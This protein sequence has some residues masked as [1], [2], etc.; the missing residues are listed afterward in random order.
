MRRKDC[1]F[2]K[3][4]DRKLPGNIRYEDDEVVVF[5]NHLNWV[6]TMLLIVPR[7]HMTQSDLWWS[8][9][10]LARMGALAEELGREHAPKGFRV[11]SNF[12]SDAMQTQP[13]GHLHVIGGTHLG[14]Y[15]RPG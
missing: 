12:G 5:D 1:T 4:V 14:L 15:V 7:K 13:H 8:G 10:L 3:V 11:L 9:E 2:C 6:P